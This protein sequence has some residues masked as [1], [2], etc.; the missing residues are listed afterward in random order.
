[1][2]GRSR[3]ADAQRE[4]DSALVTLG[5]FF[6]DAGYTPVAPPH[7]YL[8]E[9]LLSLYGEDLRARAFLFADAERDNELCLRPD[10][11]VP[12]ALVHRK[13]GWDQPGAYSYQG[14]VF[15]R[16]QRGLGRPVEYQQAGI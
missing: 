1:M 15:R 2:L 12:V 5:A 8:G 10:F 9:T 16:Q 6:A 13:Q 4:L 7:L 3:V 11:T 14:P